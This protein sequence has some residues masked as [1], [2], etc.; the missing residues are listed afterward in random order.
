MKLILDYKDFSIFSNHILSA[1]N[2][3]N[4]IQG[5]AEGGLHL[6]CAFVL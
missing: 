2:Q 5:S 4:S 3:N 6:T 1:L